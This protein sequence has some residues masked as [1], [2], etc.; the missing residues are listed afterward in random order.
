MPNPFPHHYDTTLIWRGAGPA[1]LGGGERPVI[2]GGAA[3]EFGG[4]GGFWSP[5]HLL[6]S[7]LNLCLQETFES[8]ARAEGLEIES[9]RSRASGTLGP[10][11]DGV[12]FLYLA[13]DVQIAARPEHAQ[14]ARDLL[15]KAKHYCIVART[16]MP[17]VHLHLT[18]TSKADSPRPIAH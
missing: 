6:L 4:E 7:S 8:Y 18:V 5:E 12:G 10:I 14:R 13:L 11:P 16:L 15:T 1:S 3:P 17:P 9:Y 2:T